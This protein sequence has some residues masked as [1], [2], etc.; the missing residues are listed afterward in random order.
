MPSFHHSAEVEASLE[1]VME[2]HRDPRALRK[3]TPLPLQIHRNHWDDASGQAEFTVWFG[4]FPVRWKA[5]LE[6]HDQGFLD[7]QERGPL[8]TWEHIHSFASL[9]NQR[10]RIDDDIAYTYKPGWRGWMSRL[11]FAPPAL[12]VLFAYRIFQ[13]KRALKN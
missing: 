12:R 6:A 5:R 2:F 8:Q 13:T 1:R 9:S 11:A 3:L 10:T 4:P 7:R